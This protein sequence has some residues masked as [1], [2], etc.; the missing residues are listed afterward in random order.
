MDARETPIGFLPNREDIDTDGLDVTPDIM[1]ALLSVD[2][3]QWQQEMRSVGEY[4]E[5]FGDRL[6][7]ALQDEFGRVVEALDHSSQAN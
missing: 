7:E 5:S 4:L 2:T 1:D 6:P 3:E